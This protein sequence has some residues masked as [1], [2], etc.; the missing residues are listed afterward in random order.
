MS[1]GHSLLDTNDDQDVFWM[2]PFFWQEAG[3]FVGQEK[4]IPE[5]DGRDAATRSPLRTNFRMH[6]RGSSRAGKSGFT[7]MFFESAGSV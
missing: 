4:H 7:K 2:L 6:V 1:F 3:S 5:E